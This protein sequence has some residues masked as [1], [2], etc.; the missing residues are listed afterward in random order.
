MS[1]NDYWNEKEN[2][3]YQKMKVGMEYSNL[4]FSHAQLFSD[5]VYKIVRVIAVIATIIG[6][7]TLILVLFITTRPWV[8]IK[9]Q[10]NPDAMSYVEEFYDEKFEV[11]SEE[12]QDKISIYKM[13]PKENP[14]IVFTMYQKGQTINDDYQ[15]QAYKYFVENIVDEE[16]RKELVIDVR[17]SNTNG[18][19]LL[20]YH[21]FLEPTGFEQIEE[22]TE[23]MYKIWN[24]SK[25]QGEKVFLN[26]ASCSMIRIDKYYSSVQYG[27]GDNLEDLKVKEK[28]EYLN[29]IKQ[30]NIQDSSIPKEELE[31]YKPLY[32]HASINGEDIKIKI[33]ETV[34][35][36]YSAE[37]D[38][39][40]KSYKINLP[41]IFKCTD[42]FKTHR[43]L[44]GSITSF[45]FNGKKYKLDYGI[46]EVKGNS[47]PLQCNVTYL[48][49]YFGANIRYDYEKELIYI[50]F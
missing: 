22:C 17:Q 7:L 14:E 19:N 36:F 29:Y 15:S 24:E 37:Y 45:K 47:F 41:S 1:K 39:I 8:N 16:I 2:E 32:L 9:N 42:K 34:E 18:V 25:A 46:N 43:N 11:I 20:Y 5:I 48:Q 23:E 21:A 50:D 33:G 12:K 44:A 40:V 31:N 49:Q 28:Y 6:I 26:I 38:P 35:C 30:N 3:K 4:D 27:N 10:L 13:R